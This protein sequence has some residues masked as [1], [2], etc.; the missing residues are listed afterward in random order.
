MAAAS[1]ALALALPSAPLAMTNSAA[2]QLIIPKAVASFA[3]S[4]LSWAVA[5]K[6]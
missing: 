6:L 1:T 5:H 4:T 2:Q 3:E